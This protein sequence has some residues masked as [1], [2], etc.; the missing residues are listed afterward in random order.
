MPSKLYGCFR[1]ETCVSEDCFKIAKGDVDDVQ[2]LLK[3]VITGD[4]SWV[5]GY[6]LETKA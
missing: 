3:K 4:E 1:H 5:Y 2:D 6:D